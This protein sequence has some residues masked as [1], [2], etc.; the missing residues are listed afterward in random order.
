MFVSMNF[1]KSVALS[2]ILFIGACTQ[3][4]RGKEL[5]KKHC[6]ACHA[7]P[8]PGLLSK[9]VWTTG[10]FP[11]MRVRMGLDLSRL[12]GTD[13]EEMNEMLHALPS[14]PLVSDEDF[15]AIL[16]YYVQKAPDAL[17]SEDIAPLF[18]RQF[19]PSPASL[20]ITAN[21]L[22]TC[23][24][25]EERTQRSYVGTRNSKLFMLEAGFVLSDSIDLTGPASDIVFAGEDKMFVTSMGIMDPN[26]L[27]RGSVLKLN[28]R[29][30]VATTVAD[31]IKRPVDLGYKDLN[32]DERSEFLVSAFGNFTGGL[33]AFEDVN[34]EYIRHTIHEFP[35][36]R[37]S[38]V[39]DINNDGLP[40]IIALITQGDERIALFT[41]RGDF[42]FSYQVL[43]KFPPVYGSSYLEL[44]DFN[45]DG[46]LDILYTN[47]DNAD[48]SMILKPYHGVRIFLNDGRNKF[49]ESWFH[50]MHGASMAKAVDFDADGD[51]DIAAI[52][53][54][55]D[56]ENHPEH[57]FIYFESQN[58]K[59]VPHA[60]A[61]AAA[62]R[63]ITMEIAD[64]DKDNDK[65]IVLAALNFPTGV[66]QDLLNRWNKD[67]VSLLV[68]KNNHRDDRAIVH[69]VTVESR[70][71]YST[72]TP[73]R[74]CPV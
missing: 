31:A 30:L 29:S 9:K 24:R 6:S 59:F 70:R 33:H 39:R 41:N 44:A 8:E 68:L 73:L 49:S 52:A 74:A 47:G 71:S 25:I 58:G 38:I 2:L 55:P 22:L 40:D 3:D 13:P 37:K 5:A 61:M 16:A 64:I 45:N 14:S 43:L 53:F 17:R 19:S 63:W 56:F 51:L 57:G 50:P 42:K 54:F 60:S 36:N 32:D 26:D 67:K 11:E 69:D 20:H 7:Y 1:W 18:L 15:N 27:P 62:G 21:T 4:E 48:Y 65:D 46:H 66:P 28:A 10:V 35:G 72:Q 34:G 23:L 12:A